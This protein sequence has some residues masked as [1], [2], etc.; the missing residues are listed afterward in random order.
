MRAHTLAHVRARVRFQV[1]LS[2]VYNHHWIFNPILNGQPAHE[3][4][5][6][7]DTGIDFVVGVGAESRHSPTIWPDGHGYIVEEGV[8]WNANIHLLK[9]TDLV[10]GDN[11]P[12]A[13]IECWYGPGKTCTP[14][15]NG[16]FSCCYSDSS[17]P[18]VPGANTTQAVYYLSYTVDYTYDVTAITSIDVAIIMAPECS[19]QYDAIPS[20]SP[21]SK[22]QGYPSA[23]PDGPEHLVVQK[24]VAPKDIEVICLYFHTTST[25]PHAYT[26]ISVQTCARARVLA[27]ACTHVCTLTHPLTRTHAR[28]HTRTH[29]RA[30]LRARRL[31]GRL[32]TSTRAQSISLSSST[33][34][35]YARRCPC[36]APNL[37]SRATRR[38]TSSRSRSASGLMLMAR[39]EEKP[40]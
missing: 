2:E 6:C 3:N 18:T 26:D 27:Y 21:N 10:G 14:D 17:C 40:L 37:T 28:A 11:G 30:L 20:D 33:A 12:K 35:S 38:A 32:R 5:A 39:S 4:K 25:M 34:K 16:T 23:A 13:C 29:T 19:V 36:T 7:P 24:F 8:E 1:P 31:F 15:A 9:T 22:S